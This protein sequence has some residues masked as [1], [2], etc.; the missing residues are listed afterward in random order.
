[1]VD[2]S[3]KMQA[4]STVSTG[5]D[6]SD[7]A[8]A[9]GVDAAKQIAAAKLGAVARCRVSVATTHRYLGVI[10]KRGES[11]LL[12][13]ERGKFDVN[14]RSIFLRRELAKLAIARKDEA[15]PARQRWC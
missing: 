5:S 1:M 13:V 10:G 12:G 9:A 7:P 4:S 14:S 6:F 11:G 8:T 3:G 2:I 15:S